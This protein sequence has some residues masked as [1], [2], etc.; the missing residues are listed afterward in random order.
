M[1]VNGEGLRVVGF[2]AGVHGLQGMLKVEPM[3]DFPERFEALSAVYVCRENEPPLLCHVKRV[4]FSGAQVHIALKEV[5]SREDAERLRGAELCVLEQDTWRL[6]QDVYYADS[7]LGFDA[8]G[9][10]GTRI[11]M[12]KNIARGAQDILEID[13]HGRELL[14]PFVS[15]WVGK[16]EMGSRTIEILNWRRLIEGEEIGGGPHD[17]H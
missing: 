2:V 16:I 1:A 11:G 8:V 6:P 4:R 13:H 15:E 12:L 10:D 7:L 14:V 5:T 17:G 3:S 9:D